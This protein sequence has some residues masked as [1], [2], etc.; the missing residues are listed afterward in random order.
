[1]RGSSLSRGGAMAGRATS[2]PLTR[3][4]TGATAMAPRARQPPWLSPLWLPSSPRSVG[5]APVICRSSSS[6]NPVLAH[7]VLATHLCFTCPQ[8]CLLAANKHN[9][10]LLAG[11]SPSA[12]LVLEE[13]TPHIKLDTSCVTSSLCCVHTHCC[14]SRWTCVMSLTI[15]T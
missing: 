14:M 6:A 11:R 7:T 8:Q 3:W 15:V 10:M 13:C 9:N 4:A 2:C 1:M 5:P 12:F